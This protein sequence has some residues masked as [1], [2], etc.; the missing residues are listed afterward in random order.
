MTITK[1]PTVGEKS[2]RK[3]S[4][5]EGEEPTIFDRRSTA[6]LFKTTRIGN[7]WKKGW[8]NLRGQ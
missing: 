5:L 8:E 6:I 7:G 1:A 3:S 4:P 2:P